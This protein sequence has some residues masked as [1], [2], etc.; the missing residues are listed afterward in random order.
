MD[1]EPPPAAAAA[2]ASDEEPEEGEEES[3]TDEEY[4]LKQFGIYRALPVEGEPDWSTG[5]RRLE[6]RG[7]GGGLERRGRG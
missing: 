7:W 1:P 4:D 2:A 5:G 3:G 6:G